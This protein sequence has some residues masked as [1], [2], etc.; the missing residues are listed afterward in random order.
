[1]VEIHCAPGRLSTLFT[2]GKRALWRSGGRLVIPAAALVLAGLLT[3]LAPG[4]LK[5]APQAI[6][7]GASVSLS[8]KYAEPSQMIQAGYQL[9]E[10]Q[11][12]VRGGLLNRP[13]KLILLD[14]HSRVEDA[15]QL[16]RRLIEKEAVDLLLSPYGSPMTLAASEVSEANG[17]VML[18][19]AASAEALFNRGYRNLFGVYAPARR[20][21]IGLMDL[22]A[23]HGIQTVAI[24]YEDSPFNRDVAEGTESWARR[25]GLQ[26]IFRQP[27]SQETTDLPHAVEELQRQFPS[28]EGLVFSA[29]PPDCYRLLE[30][31]EARGWRPPVLA[32]TIAPIHPGFYQKA[33]PSAEGVFGPSQW[34]PDERIPFPGTRQFIHDFEVKYGMKPSYHAASAYT[35]CQILEQAVTSTATLDQETI[36]NFIASMDSVTVIGRFKVDSRGMQIGHNPFLIQWQNGEKEIVYPRKLQTAAPRFSDE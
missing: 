6:R 3:V 10:K 31:L 17:Y 1:M 14:D 35:A 25:F 16:Y 18:A 7:I 4:V 8:G 11:I 22:M 5:A 28:T 27:F 19:C 32:Q 29:Y 2:R 24:L 23:R 30:I 33:G 9:W 36:R 20:Y 12:N 15:R 21:F 13:V 26:V 34:E